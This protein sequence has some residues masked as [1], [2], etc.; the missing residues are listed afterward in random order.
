MG[1]VHPRTLLPIGQAPT[2]ATVA[3]LAGGKRAASLLREGLL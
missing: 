2:I 1:H 3:N